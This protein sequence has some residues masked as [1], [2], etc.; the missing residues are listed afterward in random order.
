MKKYFLTILLIIIGY[1]CSLTNKIGQSNK[2]QIE[3]CID[4]TVIEDR[5]NLIVKTTQ[6]LNGDS[7]KGRISKIEYFHDNL[8]L[9]EINR[10]HMT[11]EYE[12]SVNGDYQ[13]FYDK[14]KRLNFKYFIEYQSGDTTKYC[15]EYFSNNRD[16]K[17][18]EYDF[19]RRLK[20]GMPHGDIIEEQDLTKERIWL[21]NTTRIYY[22]DE[23][24]NLVQL[25]QPIKDSV[26]YVQNK[27]TYKYQGIKLVEETS[28]LNDTLL[29]WIE[30]Y[31]YKPDEIIMT[32][33]NLKIEKGNPWI[34]PSYF[35]ISKLDNDG[36][37]IEIEEIDNNKNLMTRFLNYYDSNNRLVKM[38]CF[39][40]QNTLK[41]CHKILYEK[42]E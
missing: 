27:Y 32:H 34:I 11:S 20:S 3:P 9:K 38:E 37:P 31:E 24:S 21:Y 22:Y 42:L 23:N 2:F 39:D 7:I 8:I 4:T 5:P 26:I 14:N 18:L 41:V 6:F 13:Y 10:D 29:Y 25:Y 15:R 28:Y 36:N 12:G 19:R 40:K 1:S 35:K 33:N 16:Y 30:K 17:E